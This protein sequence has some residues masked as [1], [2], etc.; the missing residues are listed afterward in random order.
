MRVE[1]VKDAAVLWLTQDPVGVVIGHVGD[2]REAKLGE[3][4][5]DFSIEAATLALA[6]GAILW[7]AG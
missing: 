4:N 5:L 1:A 6:V 3:T 2:V 7:G